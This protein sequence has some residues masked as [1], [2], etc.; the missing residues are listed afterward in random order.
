M[1]SGSSEGESSVGKEVVTSEMVVTWEAMTTI[2]WET[3]WIELR[4]FGWKARCFMSSL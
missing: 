2:G 4:R 1:T 3:V